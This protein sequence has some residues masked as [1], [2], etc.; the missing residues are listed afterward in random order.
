MTATNSRAHEISTS[1]D[2]AAL[3]ERMAPNGEPFP[4]PHQARAMRAQLVADA[5]AYGWRTVGDVEDGDW[6]R[7]L[8]QAMKATA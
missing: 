1:M 6:F 7:M 5:D 8:D 3:A 4:A 2:L